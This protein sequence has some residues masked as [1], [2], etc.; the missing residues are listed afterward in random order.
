MQIV[1]KVPLNIDLIISIFIYK[2]NNGTRNDWIIVSNS[3][4]NDLEKRGTLDA[5]V[6][7]FCIMYIV[8]TVILMLSF[9]RIWFDVRTDHDLNE[10]A[11]ENDQ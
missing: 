1:P 9:L 10:N 2:V 3:V 5:L 7:F 11:S 8:K 4:E 6:R